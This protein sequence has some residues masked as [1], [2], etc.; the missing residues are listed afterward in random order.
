MLT[1]THNKTKLSFQLLFYKHHFTVWNKVHLPTMVVSEQWLPTKFLT[2]LIPTELH[3]TKMVAWTIGGKKQITRLS[4]N[5]RIKLLSSLMVW[6]LTERKSTENW[7]FLKTWQT[8]AVW[9]AHLRQP[10]KM[11]ISLRVIS[12]SILQ[13]FGAWKLVQSTC[14]CWQALTFTLLASFVLTSP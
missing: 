5:V 14:K 12:I 4:R 13:P 6:I 9:L 11:T 1:T 3:L 2:P 8:L 10:N 7:R